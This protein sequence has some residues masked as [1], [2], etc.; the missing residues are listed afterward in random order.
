MKKSIIFL[1]LLGLSVSCQTSSLKQE[2]LSP[3]NAADKA[4][5][6]FN[7]A[8]A[9][10]GNGS[11]SDILLQLGQSPIDIPA[12]TTVKFRSEDPTFH[13]VPFQN[14]VLENVATAEGSGIS[15]TLRVYAP[16]E[17]SYITINGKK[18]VLKQFHFHRGS[19]HAIQG[20][21]GLMEVHLVHVA[22]D[23][24]IAVIGVLLQQGKKNEDFERLVNASPREA[25]ERS[26]LTGAIDPMALLP[27][28]KAIY[29]NY[30]GSL[31]T[32]T[33]ALYKDGLIWMVFKQQ[34]SL[35]ASQVQAYAEIYEEENVR[36]LQPIGS[37]TIYERVNTNVK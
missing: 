25:G 24:K 22:K 35:A 13:Y 7:L 28:S 19:E 30:S 36:P 3:I 5:D 8:H 31:T 33:G 15:E 20:K 1:G 26:E 6:Q 21:K 27:A 32:G 4:L 10:L 17:D 37:R 9:R 34:Q 23:G 2:P 14:P 16:N 11:P 12:N 29:Y 18:Y